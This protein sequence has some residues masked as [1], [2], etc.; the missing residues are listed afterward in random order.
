MPDV[1][2]LTDRNPYQAL[3]ERYLRLIH[4]SI[5]NAGL[6]VPEIT[7]VVMTRPPEDCCPDLVVWVENVR[8]FDLTFPSGMN[9]NRMLSHF[10][11]AFDLFVRLGQCYIESD[12]KGNLMDIGILQ[13]WTSNINEYINPIYTIPLFEIAKGCVDEFGECGQTFLASNLNG[14]NL[15][16]CA[17]YEYVV[18]IGLFT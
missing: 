7:G 4:Q 10:A 16:G 11:M 9:E 6:T 15:G 5:N 17:G 1:V 2:L 13:E 8:P 18:T 12:D 3:A 14:Y